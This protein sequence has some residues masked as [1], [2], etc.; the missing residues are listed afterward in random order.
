MRLSYL[1]LKI[2]QSFR[3]SLSAGQKSELFNYGQTRN[4]KLNLFFRS[5]L[6]SAY[7]CNFLVNENG[8]RIFRKICCSVPDFTKESELANLWAQRDF[9][10]QEETSVCSAGLQIKA[11]QNHKNAKNFSCRKRKRNANIVVSVESGGESSTLV[12]YEGAFAVGLLE[13]FGSSSGTRWP[14]VRL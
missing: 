9:R 8:G 2:L 4:F 7:G 12:A 5:Y 3:D 6:T 13:Q 1:L 14:C 10:G 11:N